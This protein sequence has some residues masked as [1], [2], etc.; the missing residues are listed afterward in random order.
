MIGTNGDGNGD[1]AER[2]VISGNASQGVYIGGTGTNFNVV[3]GNLI[4]VD[5]TGANAL[6]NGNNGVWIADGAQSNRIGVQRRRPRRGGRAERDRG[7]Q[8]LRGLDQR[9][10]DQLQHGVREPHRHR[11]DWLAHLGNGGDG[12]SITNGAQSNTIGGSTALANIIYF[13]DSERCRRVRQRDDREH[14]PL[15]LDPRATAGWGSIWGEMG[16]HPTTAPGHLRSQQPG[17]LPDHHVGRLRNDDH[18]RHFVR[19]SAQ[20]FLH[21]RLLC[22]PQRLRRR[23]PLARLSLGDDGREWTGQ[24]TDDVQ[25]PGEHQPRPMDHGDGHRSGRRYFR[26]LECVAAPHA[27]VPGDCDPL[28]HLSDLRTVPDFHRDSSHRLAPAS[29]PR[30][31]PF[32][33]RSMALHSV[34]PSRWSTVPPRAVS[35]STLPAGAHTISAV[36]SG[37]STYTTFTQTISQTIT[38]APLTITARSAAMTSGAVVPPLSVSYSGF[39]NGDSPASLSKQP[40]VTTTATSLSPPGNYPIVATGATS[41]NYTIK[42]ASGILVVTPAP[43]TS[44]A[45]V[46]TQKPTKKSK[47]ALTGY[48]FSFDST[49]S[50]A[51]GNPSSYLVQTYVKVKVK[52]KVGK[53]T[54]T[55]TQLQLRPVGFTVN[56]LPSSNVVQLLTGKQAFTLGGQITLIASGITSTAGGTLDGN[57][58]GIGGDNA[59]YNIAP[60]GMSIHHA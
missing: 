35:T 34:R 50:A 20:R 46:L 51:A 18:G 57:G 15:Q 45:M 17:E 16:S 27:L 36:Y 31:E 24:A 6:G 48:Q 12:V 54:Q 1:A 60:K 28:H 56:Y 2:N 3:A 11:F 9:P 53:R 47:P 39:V 7:Q 52:V 10:G 49:M 4:G 30:R 22:D 42:Y 19:Q 26:I 13:N 5:I 21:D 8:P 32:S 25:P 29:P 41:P 37:D 58:D 33:S 44:A 38:P 55:Q 43:K 59:V 14:D 40:S 23:Q